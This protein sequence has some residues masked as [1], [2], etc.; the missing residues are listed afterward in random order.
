MLI[1]WR[2]SAVVRGATRRLPRY[3]PEM[4]FGDRP[5]DYHESKILES[6]RLN[7]LL[8][9]GGEG[10]SNRV[11]GATEL[12]EILGNPTIAQTATP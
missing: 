9:P 3:N 1:A 6:Q 11:V 5:G 8:Q 7:E 2:W 12:G 10:T 4:E